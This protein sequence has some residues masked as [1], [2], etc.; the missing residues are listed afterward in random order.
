MLRRRI[1]GWG[2]FLHMQLV[3]SLL[4][5]SSTR[6]HVGSATAPL[7]VPSGSVERRAVAPADRLLQPQVYSRL[8][9]FPVPLLLHYSVNLGDTAR[10]KITRF[11]V[12]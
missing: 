6:F 5:R 7:P 12:C 1:Y 8:H 3:A 2:L 11:V 9:P 4:I 10:R